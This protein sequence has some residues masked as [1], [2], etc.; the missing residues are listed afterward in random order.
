VKLS[1]PKTIVAIAVLV[2]CSFLAGGQLLSGADTDSSASTSEAIRQARIAYV[3]ALVDHAKANLD[4]IRSVNKRG[5]GEIANSSI[6]PYESDLALAES[7]LKALQDN[8]M[9]SGGDYVACLKASLDS[10]EASLKKLQDIN[11]KVP[12]TV[13]AIQLAQTQSDVALARARLKVAEVAMKGSPMERIEAQLIGMQD[14]IRELKRQVEL[15][16]SRN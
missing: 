6:R 4:A 16:Q 14:D 2:A 8:K 11:A 10:S 9:D 7:R 15:L 13:P 3:Q 5:A 1:S 12:N